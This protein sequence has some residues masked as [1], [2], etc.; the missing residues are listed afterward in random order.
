MFGMRKTYT[1]NQCHACQKPLN[2]PN[3]GRTRYFCDDVCKQ[4]RYRFLKRE[5]E[6]RGKRY[7]KPKKTNRY[8]RQLPV[9]GKPKLIRKSSEWTAVYECAMCGRHFHKDRIRGRSP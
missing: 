6:G 5:K 9:D 2:Q 1:N 4:K 8:E 7:R 3:T